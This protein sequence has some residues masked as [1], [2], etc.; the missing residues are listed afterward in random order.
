MAGDL[1][2]ANFGLPAFTSY[3][4]ADLPFAYPP[5]GLYLLALASTIADTSPIFVERILPLLFATGCIPLVYLIAVR[6]LGATHLALTAALAYALLP[7]AYDWLI[8]G[9]GVTRAPGLLLALLAIYMSLVAFS[10]RSSRIAIGAG[11]ALG[12]AALTHPEAAVFGGASIGLLTL[13]EGARPWRLAATSFAVA[14][15]LAAP[16]L[17]LV[18]VRHGVEPLLAARASR[19]LPSEYLVVATFQFT[20]AEAI[21]VLQAIG[22]AGFVIQVVRRHFLLPLWLILCFVAAPA[23]GATV[24][25]VPWALLVARVVDEAPRPVLSRDQ[26]IG[27]IACSLAIISAVAAPLFPSSVARSLSTDERD[28]MGWVDHDTSADDS[29]LVVT[30]VAWQFDATAEWFPVLADRHN[31]STVQGSE[32]T[33]P[34]EWADR[35]ELSRGVQA[36]AEADASCLTPF[37][38]GVDYIYIPKGPRRGPLSDPECC[39]LL[40]RSLR[41]ANLTVVF[42]GPG[43][44]VF[45]VPHG[46]SHGSPP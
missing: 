11:A 33:S 17:L 21:P 1:Q 3:N 44:T 43:A 2:H 8:A 27:A 35:L 37:L 5:G 22:L 10:S 40:R 34:Q 7:R 29:F 12:A 6:L 45:A 30:G 38:T 36:C 13:F 24:A 18:V 42:D 9:G 15:G 19:S 23:A 4:H 16:W 39:G 28:A 20:G 14:V 41:D 32:W 25:M 31:V 26:I 46:L